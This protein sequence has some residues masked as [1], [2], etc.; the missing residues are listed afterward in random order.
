MIGEWRFTK[1]ADRRLAIMIDDWKS[2]IGYLAK[3][4]PRA[5]LHHPDV[6]LGLPKTDVVRSHAA[7]VEVVRAAGRHHLAKAGT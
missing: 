4:V 3:K 1:N 2:I 6:R 7:L 5:V